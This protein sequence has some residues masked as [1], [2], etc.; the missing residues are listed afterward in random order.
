MFCVLWS[1]ML[2]YASIMN[3]YFKTFE[4]HSALLVGQGEL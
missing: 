1:M 3:K 4:F 2:Q